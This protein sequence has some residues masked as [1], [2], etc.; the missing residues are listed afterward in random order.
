MM[1]HSSKKNNT[2]QF[3]RSPKSF[4]KK[5]K[6]QNCGAKKRIVKLKATILDE[7]AV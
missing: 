6:G 1:F 5:I 3:L 4:P 7:N 2:V